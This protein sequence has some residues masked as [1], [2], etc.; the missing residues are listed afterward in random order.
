MNR[1]KLYLLVFIACTIGFIW[2]AF[3]QT[4]WHSHSELP[5]CFIKHTTSI[6][7]PSCGTTRS[8]NKLVSGDISSAFLINPMGILSALLLLV[9]PLWIIR[10]WF[11]RADSFFRFYQYMEQLIRRP[12]IAWPLIILV[13]LNWIWNI[14]KGL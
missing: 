9:C 8:I 3:H 1:N 10:D 5:L 6:P 11:T 12:I 13:L 4:Q 14:N 7:C 2:I